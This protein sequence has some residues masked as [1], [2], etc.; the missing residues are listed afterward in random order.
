MIVGNVQDW[1]RHFVSLDQRLLERIAAVWPICAANLPTQP[2]EDQVTINLVALLLKDSVVRRLCHW[3]EYQFEPFGTDANGTKFSK[4]II[5]LAVLLDWERE[6]YLAYEC[7][8]LNVTGQ[9]GRRSLA[10]DYVID[11]MMRFITEQYAEALPIGCMLGYVIDGD[12]GFA[13]QQV[14]AAIRAH[15]PLGLGSGPTASP[16]IATMTRF[17][18]SHTRA[19]KRAIE[20]RHALIPFHSGRATY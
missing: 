12:C 13:M 15:G 1:Q 9:T 6:R 5:D 8:R 4:G 14:D 17:L 7:K 16:A 20:I 2:L 3:I 10:A 11:G 19:A 18:T